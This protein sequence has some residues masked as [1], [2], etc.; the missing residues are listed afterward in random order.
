MDSMPQNTEIPVVLSCLLQELLEKCLQEEKQK[1]Q[2]AVEEAIKVE[3]SLP[4]WIL[5]LMTD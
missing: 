4:S 1:A 3:G 2:D 5:F